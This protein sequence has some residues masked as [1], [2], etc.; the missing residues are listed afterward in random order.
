MRYADTMAF[1][2]SPI[3]AGIGDTYNL[4]KMDRETTQVSSSF[5][6]Q[7]ANWLAPRELSKIVRLFSLPAR[8]NH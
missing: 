1:A 7:F 5:T 8:N 6:N 2:G 3:T 4:G